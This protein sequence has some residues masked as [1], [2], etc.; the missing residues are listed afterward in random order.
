MDP[1]RDHPLPPTGLK[2]HRRALRA[3][4]SAC[5]YLVVAS[6]VLGVAKVFAS[7]LVLPPLFL[8]LLAGAAVLGLPLTLVL[9]WRHDPQ[10]GSPAGRRAPEDREPNGGG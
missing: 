8:T 6:L 9:A 5:A 3:L 1:G 10:P 7:A 2:G 4:V